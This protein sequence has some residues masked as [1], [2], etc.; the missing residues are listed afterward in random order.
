VTT[1]QRID[2]DIPELL[3]ISRKNIWEH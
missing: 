1:F 3:Q 2:M